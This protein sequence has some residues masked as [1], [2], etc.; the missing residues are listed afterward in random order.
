MLPPMSTAFL[1]L[2]LWLICTVV[3]VVFVGSAV[4]GLLATRRWVLPHLDMEREDAEFG[5]AM[6]QAILVFYALAIA[7]VAV[8]TWEEHSAQEDRS[9]QEAAMIA[10]MYRQSQLYPADVRAEL[11]RGLLAYLT[12]IVEEDWPAQARGEV[13]NGGTQLVGDLQA[14]LGAYEPTSNGMQAV[15]ELA[16]DTFRD[17][18]ELRRLRLDAVGGH[19]SGAMWVF[20]LFGAGLSIGSA[21]LFVVADL[22]LHV[23]LVSLLA[24]IIGMVVILI[25]AYDSP[26]VGD[27]GVQPDSY[28]LILNA[29]RTP[30]GS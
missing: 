21:Y 9:S 10:T 2:P 18:V 28:Q 23:L 19:L 22:K 26:F 5:G 27:L 3:I 6:V 16:L 30:T 11:D 13:P 20:V 12:H 24:T 15:H 14:T 7:L 1:S 25:A 8:N 4:L 29:P 17:M